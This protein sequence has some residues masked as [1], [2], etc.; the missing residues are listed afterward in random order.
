MYE[1]LITYTI[2]FYKGNT[3][4]VNKLVIED[5]KRVSEEVIK[6]YGEIELNKGIRV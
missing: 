2:I 5:N 4:E 3:E 6:V 1:V